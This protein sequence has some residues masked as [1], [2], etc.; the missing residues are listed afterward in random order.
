[1]KLNSELTICRLVK[2]GLTMSVLFSPKMQLGVKYKVN[3]MN[4][5]FPR[6]NIAVDAW[7]L[8]EDG[9]LQFYFEDG[10]SGHINSL[11]LE[12]ARNQVS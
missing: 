12:E 7:T 8:R 3:V 11:S 5:K 10:I 6:R 2:T 9:M 4:S 1:M